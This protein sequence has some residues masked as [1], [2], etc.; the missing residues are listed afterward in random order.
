MIDS[1]PNPASDV[2]NMIHPGP[3]WRQN[4]G[5]ASLFIFDLDGT[6]YPK[7]AGLTDC[8]Y[9]RAIHYLLNEVGTPA[10]LIEVTLDN[11]I[12]HFGS[13]LGGLLA[14][15]QVNPDHYLAHAFD[16]PVERYLT[17]SPE[18]ARMLAGLP[19][20]RCIFSNSPFEHIERVLHSLAVR[21]YFDHIFDIRT[22]QYLGKPGL[23]T[24]HS[25]LEE[26]GALPRECMMIE[27]VLQNLVPAK[28]LGM[29]TVLVDERGS[30][31]ESEDVD[32]FIQRVTELAEVLKQ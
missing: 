7:S 18:L 20:E 9:Q 29:T 25:V 13:V 19:G 11:Y 4:I 10:D 24:Y 30:T 15:D 3:N 26:L 27:D 6:L 14:K 31:G 12:V 22:V 2:S 16:V 8:L 32:F 21:Q 23:Q 5:D 17:A 1:R 28:R